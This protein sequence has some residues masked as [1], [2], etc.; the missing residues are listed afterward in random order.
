M[1]S[2]SLPPAREFLKRAPWGEDRESREL[3][4][5]E[6]FVHR[7]PPPLR[8]THRLCRRFRR[9]ER[10]GR[11][12][13]LRRGPAQPGPGDSIA[14]RPYGSVR[15]QRGAPAGQRSGQAPPVQR[16][17][18]CPRR[19]AALPD[20]RPA[21]SRRGQPG[22]GQPRQRP[23]QRHGGDRTGQPLSATGGAGSDLAA[24]TDQRRGT[25]AGRAGDDPAER[26]R[27]RYGADQ[28]ALR[29]EPRQSAAGSVARFSPPGH[30]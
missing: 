5:D 11:V 21:L 15:D 23:R 14:G 12:G 8:P 26:R 17:H 28:P 7:S 16:G 1:A 20:R 4:V 22:R 29:N 25:G 18:L 6:A 9:A 10:P 19:A 13:R 2:F 30:W 3:P 24:G 27:A